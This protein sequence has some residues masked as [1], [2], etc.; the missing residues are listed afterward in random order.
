[1]DAPNKQD[2]EREG[3]RNTQEGN[4]VGKKVVGGVNT[5]HRCMMHT[6]AVRSQKMRMCARQE[7]SEYIVESQSQNA[8]KEGRSYRMC[9]PWK[10]L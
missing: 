3:K 9:G 1:V 10:M 4:A 5:K 7:N 6:D 8:G 2:T